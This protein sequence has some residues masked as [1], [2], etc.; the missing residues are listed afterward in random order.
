MRSARRRAAGPA[1]AAGRARSPAAPGEVP[2]G[3]RQLSREG[4]T[5]VPLPPTPLGDTA[6]GTLCASN[7]SCKVSVV[8][9]VLLGKMN[10]ECK[11]VRD[12]LGPFAV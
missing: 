11:D 1:L 12:E 4:N 2:A 6:P 5:G 7:C 9:C 8:W 3:D 10:Q